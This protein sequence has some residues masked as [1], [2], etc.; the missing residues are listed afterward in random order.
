MTRGI[1][2]ERLTIVRQMK[3]INILRSRC[4]TAHVLATK[5][6]MICRPPPDQ[7]NETL[8]EHRKQELTISET[9]R[10]EPYASQNIA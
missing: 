1:E 5:M 6:T 9:D 7:H 3:N 10:N 2:D 8:S 4:Q